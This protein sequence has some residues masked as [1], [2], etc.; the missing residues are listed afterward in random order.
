MQQDV[1]FSSIANILVTESVIV[2]AVTCSIAT[3]SDTAGREQVSDIM[4]N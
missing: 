2:P 4:V 3:D 1:Q